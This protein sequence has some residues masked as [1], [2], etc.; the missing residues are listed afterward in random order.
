M[1]NER[2]YKKSSLSAAKAKRTLWHL[3]QI[4][5]A[6]TTPAAAGADNGRVICFTGS[7]IVLHLDI[8][9]YVGKQCKLVGKQCEPVS[10]AL[11]TAC[12][13]LCSGCVQ[14]LLIEAA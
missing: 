6:A 10:L 14:R 13:M 7:S 3:L 9:A 2:H 1:F 11:L 5:L 4:N 8:Q 12:C